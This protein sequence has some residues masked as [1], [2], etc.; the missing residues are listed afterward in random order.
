MPIT[1]NTIERWLFFRLHLAPAPLLDF[2]AAQAFQAVAAAYRLGVFNALADGPVTT[3][4]IARRIEADERGTALLLRALEAVGYVEERPGGYATTAMVAKWLPIVGDGLGFFAMVLERFAHLEECIR[5]GGP[6]LEPREW[7]DQR[8]GGW[9]EFQAGM[10]TLAR[11]VADEIA[12]KVKLPRDARRVVDVGGGHGLY[13]VKLCRRYPQL[14]ATIFDLPQALQAAQETIAAEHMADRVTVQTGDFWQDDL[15]SGFDAALLFNIIHANLPD[16]NTELLRKVARALN[17]G[18]RVVIL[19][20]LVGHVRGATSRAF[21]ALMGL[22][23]FNLAGGQTYAFEEIAGWLAAAGF[24][25]PRRIRLV[26]APGN[27][28]VL[29]TRA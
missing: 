7:L 19:D 20:Q 29:A 8:V 28:L 5:R 24:V 2:L 23:L 18:G 9:R 14:S 11:I 27:S 25:Y 10:V 4:Q 21:A 15:G 6:A 3:Q 17:S 13:S 12:V 16:Q 26:R 22:T 1:P